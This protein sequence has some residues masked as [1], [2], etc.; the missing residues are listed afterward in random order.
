MKGQ[1]KMFNNEKGF[2]FITANG[3]DYFVHY[4]QILTQGFKTLISGQEVE[5]DVKQTDKGPQAQNV[6]LVTK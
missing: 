5:F 6:K 2:G 3:K 4:T 1:V